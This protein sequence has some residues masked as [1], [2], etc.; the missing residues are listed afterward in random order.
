MMILTK[1][2]E[3][4]QK[5][6][7]ELMERFEHA[8]VLKNTTDLRELLHDKGTFFGKY[9]K[10][11]ALAKFSE[12]F[13]LEADF[14]N[15]LHI[16]TNRGFSRYGKEVL[17]IRQNTEFNLDEEGLPDFRSFGEEASP[18]ERVTRFTF[19]FKEGK[20]FTIERPTIYTKCVKKFQELN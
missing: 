11:V 13:K 18:T 1:T 15:H 7:S 20:I 17:E 8:Y 6:N 12:E 3:K 2:S 10:T 19:T 16:H 5:V 4:E 14:F 9:N